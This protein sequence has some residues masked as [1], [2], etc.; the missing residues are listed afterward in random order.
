MSDQGGI[1]LKSGEGKT[2]FIRDEIMSACEVQADE[3]ATV[4]AMVEEQD[5]VSGFAMTFASP[6]RYGSSFS[7]AIL[8]TPQVYTATDMSSRWS[9]RSTIMCC[10]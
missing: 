10:W 1:V 5:D 4:D 8:E 3:M 9:R 2:Y 7:T 6:V